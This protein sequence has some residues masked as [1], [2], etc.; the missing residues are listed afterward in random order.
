VLILSLVLSNNRHAHIRS[1]HRARPKEEGLRIEWLRPPMA[2]AAAISP[3]RKVGTPV[4]G[5]SM[6]QPQVAGTD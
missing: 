6:K 4:F 1:Q 3:E 5:S 2:C